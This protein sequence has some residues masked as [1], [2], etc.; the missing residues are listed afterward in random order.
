MIDLSSSHLARLVDDLGDIPIVTDPKIVRRRSRD[1]FWYSPVLNELL[2]DKSADLVVSPRNEADVIRVAA[3]C[4]RH[5]VPIT[6]RAGG[7]GNYG[8]A[9]PLRGGVLLD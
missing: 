2:N 6:V 5:R 3:V 8:Q 4:A 9:V 1:F 7:T